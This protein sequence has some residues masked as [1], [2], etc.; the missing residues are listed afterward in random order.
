MDGT[1]VDREQAAAGAMEALRVL[2]GYGDDDARR[3]R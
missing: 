2:H 3:T 1:M